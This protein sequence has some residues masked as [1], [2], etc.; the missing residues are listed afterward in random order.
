[1]TNNT[2]R[3]SWMSVALWAGLVGTFGLFAVPAAT[4]GT[5]YVATNGSDTGRFGTNNW[6]DAFLTVSNAIAYA[7]PGDTVLVSN[8]VYKFGTQLMISNGITMQGFAGASNTV[9]SGQGSVRVL[10]MTNAAAVVD[11]FTITGGASNANA[12]VYGGGVYMVG[13]ILRN[14]TVSNNFVYTT[15]GTTAIGASGGGIYATNGAVVS[16]CVIAGNT[17]SGGNNRN[18]NGGGVYADGGSTVR[19]CR[20]TGN[21]AKANDGSGGAAGGGVCMNGAPQLWNCLV[22]SNRVQR[23]GAPEQGGGVYIGSGA[24]L[25]CTVVD[26]VGVT[27]TSSGG[28]GAGVY[29]A[30]GGVTNCLIYFNTA[31]G[32]ANDFFSAG[33]TEACCCAPE[34]TTGTG[35]LIGDP[36]LVNRTAKDYH[37]SAASICVDAGTNLAAV[38]QDLDGNARPLDGD[39]NGSARHDMGCYEFVPNVAFTCDFSAPPPRLGLNA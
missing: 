37:L 38:T 26:N 17:A 16:N 5:W 12:N 29:Q 10:G 25:N 7:Q 19:E 30:G 36:Q 24:L 18:G 33:G 14:C 28:E 34:L 39:N 11:G 13:G 22:A 27:G 8:G 4:A 2:L 15:G 9:L 1:M 21:L 3:N 23:F 31:F 6:G 20:I 32:V 35:N